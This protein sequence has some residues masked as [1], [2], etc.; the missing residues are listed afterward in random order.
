METILPY[1]TTIKKIFVG[2]KTVSVFLFG[3]AA[4]GKAGKL[5]DLD[6][7][8]LLDKTVPSKNYSRVRLELLDQLGRIIRN[9][10]L[11]VAILNQASP[12]LAHLVVTQGK[13][14][15][16]QDEDQKINFQT[17]ALQKFDD[18]FYLRKVFYAYLSQRVKDNRLGETVRL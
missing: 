3:S 2:K 10:P 6:F 12:L 4:K 17:I 18:A 14:I 15:F 9:R 16:C 5:S 1:L 11:D 7:A 8:V 13:L